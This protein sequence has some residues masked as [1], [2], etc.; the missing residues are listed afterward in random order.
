MS[1]V[2]SVVVRDHYG[3][4]QLVPTSERLILA[5]GAKADP[6]ASLPTDEASLVSLL[7]A[8]LASQQGVAKTATEYAVVPTFVDSVT[9]TVAIGNVKGVLFEFSYDFEGEINGLATLGSNV[10]SRYFEAPA[11]GTLVGMTYKVTAGTL[12]IFKMILD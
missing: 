9:G 11:G 10:A 3:A 8:I 1:N 5:L 4:P 2:Q 7:K 12:T 6:A